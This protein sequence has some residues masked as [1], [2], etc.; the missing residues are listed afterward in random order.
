MKNPSPRH[1]SSYKPHTVRH[2]HHRAPYTSVPLLLWD[3]GGSYVNYKI[4]AVH[5]ELNELGIREPLSSSYLCKMETVPFCEI[6]LQHL[7][8]LFQ[9]QVFNHLQTS[10]FDFSKTACQKL[11]TISIQYFEI[12]HFSK[13]MFCQNVSQIFKIDSVPCT[14]NYIQ[15]PS[16]KAS[17]IRTVTSLEK[18]PAVL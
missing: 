2:F 9:K 12:S 13:Q 18:E 17:S 6:S 14:Q 11:N 7:N 5:G 3:Q 4:S 10:I 1:C 8:A 15:G 16:L